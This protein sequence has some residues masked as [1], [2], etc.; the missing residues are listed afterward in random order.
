MTRFEYEIS[1]HP[2]ETFE[3]VNFFCSVEGECSLKELPG[4]QV[5]ML[6]NL[7]NEQ[8]RQGWEL[9]QIFFGRDGVLAFW[10]RRIEE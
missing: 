5:N 1:A 7:L 4:D 2:A 6:M 9:V 3:Q 10:K 8:G